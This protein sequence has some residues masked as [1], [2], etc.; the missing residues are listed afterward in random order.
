MYIMNS[1]T[2]YLLENR[3]LKK[4]FNVW[5]ERILS[6]HKRE[7]YKFLQE[8]DG[9]VSLLFAFNFFIDGDDNNFFYMQFIEDKAK[10]IIPLYKFDLNGRLKKILYIKRPDGHWVTIFHCKKNSIFY[11]TRYGRLVLYK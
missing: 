10:K 2:V 11:G 7:L 3:E 8:D 4:K 9:N 5:P 6:V 1:S